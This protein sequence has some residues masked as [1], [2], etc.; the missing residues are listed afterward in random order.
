MSNWPIRPLNA[1]GILVVAVLSL[2]LFVPTANS[3]S[4]RSTAAAGDVKLQAR[5]TLLEKRL[6]E[7]EERLQLVENGEKSARSATSAKRVAATESKRSADSCASPSYL[8][9]SGVRR[10]RVE[11][12]QGTS[13]SD[14][15][16]PFV[17]DPDGIKR[18][19]TDCL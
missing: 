4:D 14:C 12:A 1:L 11:C 3:Q 19:K 10:V 17:V 15:E 5:V 13:T 7:L 6:A 9:Q 2:G 16:T 8:D 18:V